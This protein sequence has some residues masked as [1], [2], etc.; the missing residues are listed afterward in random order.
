M[1]SNGRLP[2][3][4]LAAIPAG[5]LAKPS[6]VGWNAGP[7]R[8][9]C[10]PGGP[11]SSYRDYATQVYFWNL[12]I[13]GQGNLA[14]RPGT[15]NH[16]WGNAVDLLSPWMRTWVDAHGRHFGWSKVEAPSEW[17]HVNYT[18]GYNPAPDPLRSLTSKEKR[19]AGRLL[20]HRRE[21]RRE[22]ATGRGPRYE[23]Q[24]KHAESWK[25]TVERQMRALRTDAGKTGWAK[26]NRGARYQTLKRVLNDRDGR[27]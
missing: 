6:A 17:W 13:S 19:M 18:G 8:A 25:S 15:S 24:R 21:M 11:R 7:A 4:S 5:R 12:Y 22:A 26:D 1:A 14:A 3:S 9:G 10:R 2:A 23:A 16:G 20:Y 27:L